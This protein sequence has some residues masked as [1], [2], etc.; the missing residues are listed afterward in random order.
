M[1]QISTDPS[2]F[3]QRHQ[4]RDPRGVHQMRG[5]ISF[6]ER[7]IDI[8]GTFVNSRFWGDIVIV[9]SQDDVFPLRITGKNKF[10]R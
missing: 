3:V 1:F 9:Q 7:L 2:I 5:A 4:P 8:H 10:R 6:Q